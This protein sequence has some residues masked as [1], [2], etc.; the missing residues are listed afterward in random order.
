[1]NRQKID[2]SFPACGGRILSI[3][4]LP[5]HHLFAGRLSPHARD[6]VVCIFMSGTD[7]SQIRDE[8]ARGELDGHE[9]DQG[10]PEVHAGHHFYYVEICGLPA[11]H[12]VMSSQ[13]ESR[14]WEV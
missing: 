2:A 11:T 1:M 6:Q 3:N 13:P 12:V 5:G 8:R 9:Y 14:V 4:A 7:F 10:K